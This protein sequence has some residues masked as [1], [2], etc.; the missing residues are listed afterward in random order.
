MEGQ[1]EP[2]TTLEEESGVSWSGPGKPHLWSGVGVWQPQDPGF[3][4]S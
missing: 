1:E 4:E 3:W 2:E